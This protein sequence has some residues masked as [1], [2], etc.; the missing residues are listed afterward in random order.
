MLLPRDS[1][2]AAAQRS[3]R[4]RGCCPR[5]S[6]HPQL[7]GTRTCSLPAASGWGAG[8][9]GAGATPGA[10][11]GSGSAAPLG[12]P[13]LVGPS[14]GRGSGSQGLQ[15]LSCNWGFFISTLLK[16][17]CTETSSQMCFSTLF[18]RRQIYIC[19]RFILSEYI[20]SNDTSH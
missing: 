6:W 16:S 12:T 7:T 19:I 5:H 1:I 10:V 17:F 2:S 8:P 14:V 20:H 18:L 9:P 13:A 15:L 4:L 11:H 3:T